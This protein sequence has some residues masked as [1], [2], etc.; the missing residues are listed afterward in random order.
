MTLIRRSPDGREE[1]LN[2]D[3]KRILQDERNDLLV[4]GGDTVIVNNTPVRATL[5]AV[6]MGLAKVFRVAITFGG[7]YR[8]FGDQTS[9]SG[10]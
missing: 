4:Q 3:F 5:S 6:G 1:M 2:V 8:L 7:G 9:G 10:Y